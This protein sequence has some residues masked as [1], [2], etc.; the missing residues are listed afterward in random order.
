MCRH[1]KAALDSI[2]AGVIEPC[3][4][5]FE[6]GLD[7]RGILEMFAMSG[8]MFGSLTTFLA[9]NVDRATLDR[10]WSRQARCTCCVRHGHDRPSP[11]PRPSQA[12]YEHEIEQSTD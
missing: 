6:C 9:T 12:N 7:S 8:G 3:D 11:Q 5:P 2:D 10:N 1:I 4:D